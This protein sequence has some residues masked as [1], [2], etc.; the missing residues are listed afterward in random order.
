MT[1]KKIFLLLFVL[2]ITSI[3]L[4]QNNTTNE[5]YRHLRYN[6]VSPFIKIAGTYP[7]DATT[8][9]N[10]SHYIFK[11]N[12]KEELIEIVNHHYFTERRHP[13]AS[14]GAYRTIITYENDQETRIYLDK[15]GK[16]VMNDRMVYK[17]VFT[18]NKKGNYAKL[19]FFNVNNEPMESN[20]GISEYNWFK[21]KK[22]VIE[23]RYNLKNEPKNISDYFEF[24]ITGM[25]FR[26]DGT[27]I[28]NYNLNEELKITNNSE[29][30]ASYQDSYD[31]NGN[32]VKYTYH[33]ENNTLVMNKFG[34]SIGIKEYDALGN[35]IKQVSYD[36]N[37]KLLRE[38]DITSNQY[39]KLSAKAS[40]KDSLEIK[41]ISLGYLIA[42][43]ELKPDLMNEVMNDSLNK[44]TL[45]YSRAHKKEIVTSISRKR[46]IEN[47]ESWNK[48][49]T[50]FPPKPS[51]Q[52]IILDIYHRIATV[53]LYSDNWVE[54]LHLIKLDDQWSII[55]LLWQHK[56]INRYPY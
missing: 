48:S 54:Y 12:D 11:Y 42:L 52:I 17:E 29:G 20:W 31:V 27:P 53:K 8:A 22:M 19:T 5:Y 10:T 37:M 21:K 34:L 15:N 30:V 9:K 18:L 56:D 41:R 14:I 6:H 3:T 25:M 13:L 40:Q 4:A 24:G 35:Y 23:K 1:L 36:P 28:A 46:M 7:I 2:L 44:V 55:N 38:R 33:D 50:K 39:V 16:R 43:Q 51:N 45:G 26:K 32:H 47:A 49:N